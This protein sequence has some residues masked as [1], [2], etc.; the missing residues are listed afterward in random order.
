ML[1]VRVSPRWWPGSAQAFLSRESLLPFAQKQ[2]LAVQPSSAQSVA[3]GG[4]HHSQRDQGPHSQNLRE[5]WREV[6]G[7]GI[8][9]QPVG[10]SAIPTASIARARYLE[11]FRVLAIGPGEPASRCVTDPN[12]QLRFSRD[13]LRTLADGSIRR[14]RVG[15]TVSAPDVGSSAFRKPCKKRVVSA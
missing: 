9:V 3:T 11:R 14:R 1:S 12:R 6:H 4:Q 10:E 5:R 2:A 8:L 13:S 15:V 7:R